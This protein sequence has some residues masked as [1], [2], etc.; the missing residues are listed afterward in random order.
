MGGIDVAILDYGAGNVASVAK[1][2][3]R[4][5]AEPRMTASAADLA[6]AFAIVVPG[7]GHFDRTASI[8]QDVRTALLS[9]VERRVP[10]LGIC[11]GLH[12]LCAGS[13]EAP[14]VRGLGA[15]AGECEP[16]PAGESIKVPHVGWNTLERT[17]RPSRLLEGLGPGA[18]VY[19]CHSY[20]L[21]VGPDTTA[22]S[23][24]G[25]AI[26]AAVERDRVYGVQFHPEKSGST[27]LLVLRNFLRIAAEDKAGAC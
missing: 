18:Y 9:A 3:R 13:A 6:R 14:E 7:V 11:L 17:E 16:L 1:A 12:W 4:V 22:F 19:F 5:G 20:A 8:G 25:F 21:G 24:H 2:L 27:G 26:A 23:R 15:F 10:I